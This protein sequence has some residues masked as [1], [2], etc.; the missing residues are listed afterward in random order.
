VFVR[1]WFVFAWQGA[2][3]LVRNTDTMLRPVV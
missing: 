1:E 3:A 2:M